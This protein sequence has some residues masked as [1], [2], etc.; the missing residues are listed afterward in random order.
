[1]THTSSKF[2]AQADPADGGGFG[3][4]FGIVRRRACTFLE[5]AA[6]LGPPDDLFKIVR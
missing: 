6:I 1:M 4:V 5:V 2:G 3:L